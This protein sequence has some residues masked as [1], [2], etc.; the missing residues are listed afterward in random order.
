MQ[1]LATILFSGLA[2]AGGGD[3]ENG[4]QKIELRLRPAVA[5]RG[6]DV[7]IGEMCEVLP[8]GADA[9]AIAQ[10]KFGPAPGGGYT[11]TVLRTEIVQ[12]LA[13]AGRDVAN[14]KLTGA[15]E[16]VVQAVAVD[17]PS[18]ELLESATAALQALLA[19]EGGDVEFEA[20][21]RLRQV[22]SP[23]GRHSQ[24]LRSRV[25][26]NR[27]GPTAAVVDVEVLVDGEVHKRV[28]VQFKLQRFHEVLK[29][30]GTIRAGTPLGPEN[31]VVT[32]EPVA[33]V[34]GLFLDSF[35]QVEGLIAARNLQPHQRLTL[36]DAAPPALVH[37]GEVCTVVL[38][39]GR[40]KITAKAMANHDAPLT[41]RITLTNLQSRAQLTGVVTGPGLVV[42]QQ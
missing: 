12:S 3:D 31:L 9:L 4:T 24:E 40:V 11:R 17:V 28:P 15:D 39:R 5:V 14:C 8:A 7:T 23:P 26:G 13:A 32:R 29:T 2:F 1:L 20:P 38:T 10:I 21:T 16:V 19:I 36:A 33:Q 22:Q 6:L 25:R 35:P 30:A 41:G 18:S 27:T 34:T 42:V 37:K